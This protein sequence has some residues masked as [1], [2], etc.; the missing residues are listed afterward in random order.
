MQRPGTFSGDGAVDGR[1]K[2]ESTGSTDDREV[3]DEV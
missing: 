1:G 3:V 2:M